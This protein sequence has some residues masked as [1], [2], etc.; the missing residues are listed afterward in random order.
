MQVEII[1]F[2]PVSSRTT[3]R[4]STRERRRRSRPPP[5]ASTYRRWRPFTITTISNNSN[6]TACRIRAAAWVSGRRAAAWA[7]S[8][9]NN[10]SKRAAAPSS[11]IKT[12]TG[13]RRKRTRDDEVDGGRRI[14][15][16]VGRR[17]S[18][19]ADW[20]DGA[21]SAAGRRDAATVSPC[22]TSLPHSSPPF[23]LF[24]F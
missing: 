3:N 7:N 9:N 15:V 13:T 2:L 24:L 20:S 21:L 5:K 1:V 11:P 16:D 6:N 10:S 12:R 22:R 8:S 19:V 14:R 17:S 4:D 18:V 23:P